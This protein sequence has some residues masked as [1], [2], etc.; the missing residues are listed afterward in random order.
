MTL[1]QSI[2]SLSMALLDDELVAEERREL[3]LHLLDC[4][5][6]RLHV[7]A[8]RTEIE[9]VRKALVAPPAPALL[10]ARI[11]RALD[12]EDHAAVRRER[13]RWS[14]YLLPGS[15]MAAAAAALMVFAGVGTSSNPSQKEITQDVRRQQQRRLPLEVQGASTG[16][17]MQQYFAPVDPP[18]FTQ[19]GIA[20][21]GGR[22]L[23]N[24]IANHDA[25]LLEYLVSRGPERVRLTAIV[26]KDLERNELSDGQAFR[27]H[28]L[29]LRVHDANGMPAVTY[30]DP[31]DRVG[32]VFA[33]E[34][35]TA[36]ELLQL[37]ATTDLIERA[38]QQTR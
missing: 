25:A 28:G 29:V 38:A 32:Y 24:G 36:G 18:Q 16:P 7:D 23:P 30:V 33:S 20:L 26:L 21:L 34:G 15:A 8:E 17:W 19:P 31:A 22:L 12:A 13:R 35:M 37:V 9:M 27:V 11:A 5:S 3:E 6:C 1:C 14:S 4:A 2:E 10:K